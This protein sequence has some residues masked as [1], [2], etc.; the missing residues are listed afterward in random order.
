MFVVCS[1]LARRLNE[2]PGVEG[3]EHGFVKFFLVHAGL[4]VR[5]AVSVLLVRVIVSCPPARAK[6]KSTLNRSKQTPFKIGSDGSSKTPDISDI[7]VGHRR[8]KKGSRETHPSACRAHVGT[9]MMIVLAVFVRECL[10]TPSVPC[11]SYRQTNV[12]RHHSFYLVPP[13]LWDLR[14]TQWRWP[15]A[16][17][18]PLHSSL[19][20]SEY[21]TAELGECLEGPPFGTMENRN[22]HKVR[23][24][25]D[26]MNV[27]IFFT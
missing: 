4:Q 8:P 2:Y 12:S 14:R 17:W 3:S 26:H 6:P 27:I 16:P 13:Y 15:S 10:P 20:A 1:S 18:S 9:G 25:N 24:Q 5:T 11:A 22:I 21:Y 23:G 7:M 19:G